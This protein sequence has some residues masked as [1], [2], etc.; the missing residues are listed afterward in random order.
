MPI[1]VRLL[2]L[3]ML[4]V[5]PVLALA[6]LGEVTSRSAREAE[7]RE[8]AVR[9]GQR[10][11]GE[12][13]H[14]VEGVE[15][16]AVT[17]A[18][19][20]SVSRALL[21]PDG[22]VAECTALLADL[23]GAYPDGVSAGV[24]DRDGRLLCSAQP[25][26][27]EVRIRGD[28]LRTALE[29]R[30]FVLGGYGEA[31]NGRGFLSA[32]HPIVDA[33]DGTPIGGIVIGID[34]E[35]LATRLSGYGNADQ[36]VTVA[37]ANLVYL[38]R[39]P[40]V[41]GTV[42]TSARPEHR[43]LASLAEQ[44]PI[45]ATDLAGVQR[46]GAINGLSFNPGSST[47]DIFVGTGV[48]RDAAM[49]P[50]EAA[51]RR[52]ALLLAVGLALT[53]AAAWWG[54]RRFVAAPVKALRNASERWR[55]GDYTARV[56][57]AIVSRDEFGE[58]RDAFDAMADR[59]EAR[60]RELTES[61]ERFRTLAA[62][63]PAIVWFAGPDGELHYANERWGAYTG[64]GESDIS[65]RVWVDAIHPDDRDGTHV[66]W[67]FAIASRSA[68]EEQ[69][70]LRNATGGYEWF[71][72]RA[73]PMCSSKDEVAGWFGSCTNIHDLKS[74]EEH[75]TVLLDEL[76]HRV[77]NTFATILSIANQSLR[78]DDIAQAR[79]AFEG[80]LLA[81][82]AA[83]DVLTRGFWQSV[84]L[85][86]IVA[87]AVRPFEKS[88]SSQF[89]IEGGEA[90]LDARVALAVSML[91]HELATNATKHGALSKEGGRVSISWTVRSHHVHLEWRETGGPTVYVPT[92]RGFGT[93]LLEGGLGKDVGSA[94]LNFHPDGLVCTLVVRT[95]LS[96]ETVDESDG[97][98]PAPKQEPPC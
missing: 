53:L 67:R 68:F 34:L 8:E 21:A 48:A 55:E 64:A 69:F 12:I 36:V 26:T 49:A 4:A 31:P 38:V 84:D 42:G 86:K 93:R 95:E 24:A 59:I 89:A 97:D 66:A 14:V 41:P 98:R 88:G 70:R 33:A 28:H 78:T 5:S 7:I 56:G 50:V 57:T 35:W 52:A 81:L 17:L 11:S 65:W 37:D 91:L 23:A 62:L 13:R 29:R 63:V 20:P 27:S 87:A 16:L 79:R 73:E 94:C 15:R 19:V 72:C 71:L 92:R 51:T 47:Y 45:E 1:F 58:L 10:V 25:L 30:R 83:H 61:E 43:P 54:S 39:L 77:K 46:I 85:R 3:V 9:I 18:R 76:K 22:N 96:G 90:R 6:V 32:A 75:R 74:A 44:G 40:A 2:L 82:S 60:T 80:R